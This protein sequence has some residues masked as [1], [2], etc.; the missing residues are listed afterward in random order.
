MQNIQGLKFF[1]FFSLH[2][3]QLAKKEYHVQDSAK[4]LRRKHKSSQEAY[5]AIHTNRVTWE[6]EQLSE[7]L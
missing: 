6:L 3:F 7:G 1:F 4:E 5:G 2:F